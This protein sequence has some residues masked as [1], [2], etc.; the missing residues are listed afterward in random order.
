M[1]IFG[2]IDIIQNLESIIK[3]IKENEERKL[4]IYAYHL[5]TGLVPKECDCERGT[6]RIH[7]K[8][9]NSSGY[10]LIEKEEGK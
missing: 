3:S 5:K 6:A 9:C 4:I 7:C 1:N 10:I 8:K 2:D